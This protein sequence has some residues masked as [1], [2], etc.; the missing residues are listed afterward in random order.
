MGFLDKLLKKTDP[1]EELKKTVEKNPKD[2]KAMLDL[3]N[4]LKAK[5]DQAGALE[6]TLKAAD[7]HQAAGFA[8]KA[9]AVMRQ[10]VAMAPQS[11]DVLEKLAALY[12]SMKL[13]EDA[14]GVFITLKKV[15][16][17][18]KRTNDYARVEKQIGE[19]GPGR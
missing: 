7:A 4:Q 13:K 3:A 9:L 14:R 18:D 8:Q 12:L 11:P 10:A 15:Y 16:L 2:T 1:L 17:A 5:G 6:Y 19:L